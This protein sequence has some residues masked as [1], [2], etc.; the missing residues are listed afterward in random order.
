MEQK[1]QS[2]ILMAQFQSCLPRAGAL[3]SCWGVELNDL[4]RSLPTLAILQF[5]DY[6][7]QM[8]G[9]G[10]KSGLKTISVQACVFW[11]FT[12]FVSTC[13]HWLCKAE[14][15]TV[16]Y[17]SCLNRHMNSLTLQGGHHIYFGIWN[18]N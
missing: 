1:L 2:V 13:Q 6:Q 7:I 8:C 9:L 17:M 18:N 10:K 5:F 3:C 14:V 15:L 4:L 16:L 12:G 11:R